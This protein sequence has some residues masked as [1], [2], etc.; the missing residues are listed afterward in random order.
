MYKLI[1]FNEE[2]E[3]LLTSE[4]QE[5]G[6]EYLKKLREIQRYAVQVADKKQKA[7]KEIKEIRNQIAVL[8]VEYYKT[9]NPDRIKEIEEEKTRLRLKLEDLEELS[10]L[11]LKAIIKQK[12]MKELEGYKSEAYKEYLKYKGLINS[13]EMEYQKLKDEIAG[14]IIQLRGTFLYNHIWHE[15]EGIRS[16]IESFDYIQDD[17]WVGNGTLRKA[18]VSYYDNTDNK[19][20]LEVID[21]VDTSQ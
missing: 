14:R 16:Q 12:Y 5:K 13:R 6:Q 9:S 10:R 15:A 8:N 18:T 21:R 7:E 2:L 17:G 3:N 11:N 1:S 19:D 20:R 4:S